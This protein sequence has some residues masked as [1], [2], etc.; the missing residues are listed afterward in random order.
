MNHDNGAKAKILIV[1]DENEIRELLRDTLADQF[2][3]LAV[4]SAEEALE[5]LN[6]QEVIISDIL[7]EGMSGLEMIPHVL[8]RSPDTVVLM[9]SGESSID[10]AITAMRHGAFDY[11]VKPFNLNQLVAAVQRAYEHHQLVA[12]KRLYENELERLVARRTVELD[13]AL[14]SVED[15]YRM[16]LKALAAALET[17]DHDTHGHSERV[18]AFSLR[19]G[20]ELGLGKKWLRSLEFGSL[21]HDIGKI[22]VPDAILH[23]P[24]KLTEE[25]WKTMRQHPELGGRILAGIP[26]LAGAS[27]VISQHHEMWNGHGYPLGL[28]GEEIDINARIFAVADTYDAITSDRVYRAA[29]SYEVAAAEL[30]KFAGEQF[31]PDVVAAF[32]RVPRADWDRLRSGA[33]PANCNSRQILALAVD[34]KRAALALAG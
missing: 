14:T 8:E 13:R 28:R 15:S 31:D 18:V 10:S 7:M 3:C 4:A 24:A 30:D 2:D 17:R 27:R 21:L 25:E 34:A 22:G 23:K 12:A 20:Q 6:G 1:D 16:T 32:H 9:I 11:L 19:L 26:F 29:Q 5:L 33:T